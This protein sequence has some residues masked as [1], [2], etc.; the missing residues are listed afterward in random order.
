M[1][2]TKTLWVGEVRYALCTAWQ[3]WF[4]VTRYVRLNV[5]RIQLLP[6]CS[7]QRAACSIL[8]RVSARMRAR[9]AS[10]QRRL[11]AQRAASIVA[12]AVFRSR[13][14]PR[15]PWAALAARLSATIRSSA[16]V[17]SRPVETIAAASIAAWAYAVWSLCS[18][19]DFRPVVSNSIS[20]ML[21]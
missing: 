21:I 14:G 11:G 13:C 18:R 15:M 1:P 3:S 17:S 6:Q 16:S 2:S 5:E 4:H 19:R 9:E 10:Y 8:S 12:L 20:A 7:S